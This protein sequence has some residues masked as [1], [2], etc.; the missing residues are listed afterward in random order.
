MGALYALARPCPLVLVVPP[1]S[2]FWACLPGSD[3]AAEVLADA[4]KAA[5]GIESAAGFR[6]F[7]NYRIRI[8][9]Y[10]GKLE[11]LPPIGPLNYPKSQKRR[12]PQRSTEIPT[13]RKLHFACGQMCI[14]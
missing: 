7:E 6:K 3:R 11:P 13:A 8:L 10:C 14:R 4:F 2:W 12:M 5:C 1:P 9:F